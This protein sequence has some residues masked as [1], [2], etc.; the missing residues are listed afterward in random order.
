MDLEDL[1][2]IG[3]QERDHQQQKKTRI[4]CCTAAGCLSSGAA[5]V[6]KNLET[7]VIEAG[8]EASVEVC[9]VGCLRFCGRGTL[10]EV[11]PDLI[12]Y[13]EVSPDQASE[14]ISAFQHFRVSAFILRAS[15]GLYRVCS[16][17]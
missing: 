15:A 8:L 13:Q 10:V 9:G 1:L 6:K 17:R 14:I 4:R 3:Q 5:T 12:L 11:D 16:T 7:A 2:E